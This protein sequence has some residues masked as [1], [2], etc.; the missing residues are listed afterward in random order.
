L[1][2]C[3]DVLFVDDDHFNLLILERFARETEWRSRR[4]INGEDAINIILEKCPR[5]HR[6]CDTCSVILTD[7]NMPIMNGFALSKKVKKMIRD[8]D[9]P[10]I[11]LVANTANVIEEDQSK[12]TNFDDKFTKPF[13]KK[14]I[15]SIL[16][17]YCKQRD[18][19]L[20]PAATN[21]DLSFGPRSK[22]KKVS[23]KFQEEVYNSDSPSEKS[24]VFDP[25]KIWS[26]EEHPN[27]SLL[28]TPDLYHGSNINYLDNLTNSEKDHTKS[29]I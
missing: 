7:I 21:E 13:D 29:V 28:A 15:I 12:Y 24:I 22:I 18:R 26:P 20:K 6:Y 8:K 19:K 5:G 17:K 23:E 14:Q 9:I 2:D 4:A 11:S 16:K 3:F 1:C 25:D 27:R 10:Y